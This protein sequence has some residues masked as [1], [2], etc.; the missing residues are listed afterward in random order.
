LPQVTH[1]K[2]IPINQIIRNPL[3]PRLKFDE[4]KMKFLRDSIEKNGVLVPITF[5]WN[6]KKEKYTFIDGEIA[7]Y[8]KDYSNS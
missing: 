8:L 3:N 7:R 6:L 1:L 4:R 5:F 2:N